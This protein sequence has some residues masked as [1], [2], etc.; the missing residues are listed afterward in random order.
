MGVS[1]SRHICGAA[2]GARV[3]ATPRFAI[4][5]YVVYPSKIGLFAP[6]VQ[7]LAAPPVNG[8]IRQF[9]AFQSTYT[10]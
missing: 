3:D 7:S 1:A 10:S 5:A 4:A 8:R 2:R 9:W 6:Q